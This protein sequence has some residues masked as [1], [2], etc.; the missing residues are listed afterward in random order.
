MD[1]E[2]TKAFLKCVRTDPG[3]RARLESIEK[4]S[5]PDDIICRYAEE[6]HRMGLD[7]TETDLRE[8]LAAEITKRASRTDKTVKEIQMLS[9][10]EVTD[11]AGG[12]D[13]HQCQDTYRDYE[14]CWKCNLDTVSYSDHYQCGKSQFFDETEVCG[15]D[16]LLRELM[17]DLF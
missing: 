6:A 1:I 12:R 10:D 17:P 7:V 16:F 14:N 2:K 5:D 4:Q 8:M 15:S 3:I 13:D 11:V 9:D